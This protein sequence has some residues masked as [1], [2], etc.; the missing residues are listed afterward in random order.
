M[1]GPDSL[2]EFRIRREQTA[3][4]RVDVAKFCAA[5][6]AE[7]AEFSGTDAEFVKE[8]LDIIGTYDLLNPGAE[9]DDGVDVYDFEDEDEI[10][11]W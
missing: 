8:S 1:T 2:I 7:R 10:E 5:Y 4:V 9:P 11:P 3:R 6:S